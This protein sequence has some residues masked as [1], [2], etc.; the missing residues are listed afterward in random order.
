MFEM[1]EESSGLTAAK[2]VLLV[3]FSPTKTEVEEKATAVL[4]K[5]KG[6]PNTAIF[7]VGCYVCYGWLL[8]YKFTDVCA[9]F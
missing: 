7:I 9:N 5:K 3:V 1:D 4:A 6:I 2:V 8:F